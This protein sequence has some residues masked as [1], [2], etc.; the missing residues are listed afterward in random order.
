MIFDQHQKCDNYCVQFEVNRQN[1]NL[2]K[3]VLGKLLSRL[4]VSTSTH[5]RDFEL[6]FDWFEREKKNQ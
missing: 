1:N 3:H 4:R 6:F 5:D 2:F